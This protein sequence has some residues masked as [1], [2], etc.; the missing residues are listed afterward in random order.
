[1][2]HAWPRA[3]SRVWILEKFALE[4]TLSDFLGLPPAPGNFSPGKRM[5][6]FA[7]NGM[8]AAPGNF[9]ARSVHV[10]ATNGS[11]QFS[12][13]LRLGV[14]CSGCIASRVGEPASPAPASYAVE[15]EGQD[16]AFTKLDPPALFTFECEQFPDWHS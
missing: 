8:I 10:R 5:A 9:S 4:A 15:L 6:R 14:G 1:M 11:I 16:R 12:F 7:D 13:L 2:V 3:L